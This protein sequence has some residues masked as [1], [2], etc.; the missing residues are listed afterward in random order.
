VKT[1]GATPAET[2]RSMSVPSKSEDPDFR[3]HAAWLAQV[4]EAAPGRLAKQ[5]PQQEGGRPSVS[6]SSLDPADCL[7]GQQV[8]LAPPSRRGRSLSL[9]SL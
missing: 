6:P 9:I 5:V 1:N 8:R 2:S 7:L 4:S 3:V